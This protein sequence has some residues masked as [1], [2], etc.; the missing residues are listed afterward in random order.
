M[1]TAPDSPNLYASALPRPKIVESKRPYTEIDLSHLDLHSTLAELPTHH[2]EVSVNVLGHKVVSRLNQEPD[3]PGV[4]VVDEDEV[5][6]AVSRRRF[7]ANIGR[8]YG[9]E[10]YLNRPVKILVN[11]V[12]IEHL[13]L[14]QDISIREAAEQ[15]LTRPP[16]L[17]YEPVIVTDGKNYRLLDIHTLLLAQTELL[18]QVNRIEQD[19]RQMAESLQKIGTA[20]LSSLSLKKVTRRILKEL[21]K[22]VRY[23]RGVVLLRNGDELKSIALRGYPKSDA[24]PSKIKLSLQNNEAD[25]FRRIVSTQEPMIVGDVTQDPGWQQLDWLPLN[26]SWLGVP[27]LD[28]GQ[29]IGMISLTRLDRNAFTVDDVTV[30]TAFALQAAIA[31]T[32]AQLYEQILNFNDQL[33]LKVNERTEALNQAYKILEKL[34]KTKSNFIQVSAHELRTPLTVVR[35]YAQIMNTI[36]AIK[37]DENLSAMLGGIVS[38]IDRLHHI[39]NSMLDVAKIDSNSLEVIWESVNVNDLLQLLAFSFA[40]ALGQRKLNLSLDDLSHLPDVGGDSAL[41]KKVFYAV[42]VN[43]IKFTPD[44]GSLTISGDEIME[45]G[46][47]WVSVSIS[48]TG[49]GIDQDQQ[50]LIFEKFYQT[51]ELALH[52]SGQTKFMAGGPGLGLAISKGILEA[53]NGRI[54]VESLGRDEENYPGSCFTIWLPAVE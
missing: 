17:F 18:K 28:Q 6:T 33:E 29:V 39:V 12:G 14:S 34:D 43:A 52:S 15:A 44:G 47:S 16:H 30:V 37:N 54:E 51:G 49:I 11:A 25:V 20:L 3:L 2:F 42:L 41:L 22:V 23:E 48:D 32:N 53:L 31:L 38:G 7:L 26:R 46:R 21:D 36:E 4:I 10:I 8:T 13:S 27:L 1:T 50:Q 35:G 40:D 24:V 5:V 45:N 19:R 9:L